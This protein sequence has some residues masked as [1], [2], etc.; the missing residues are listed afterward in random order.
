MHTQT[1]PQHLNFD[2]FMHVTVDTR[3]TS[4]AYSDSTETNLD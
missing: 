3:H 1:A 4:A 2:H